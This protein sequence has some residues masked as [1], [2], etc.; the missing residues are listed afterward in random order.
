MRAIALPVW[1][2][3]KTCF[4]GLLL[5]LNENDTVLLLEP[6]PAFVCCA[7]Q[8][9]TT[10]HPL[11]LGYSLS[12]EYRCDRRYLLR[13]ATEVLSDDELPPLALSKEIIYRCGL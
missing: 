11:S 2:H 8:E 4:G 1:C 5:Q 9:P 3:N 6:L 7:R 13:E 10:H 12:D